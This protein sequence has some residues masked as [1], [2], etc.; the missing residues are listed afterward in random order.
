MITQL[1]DSLKRAAIRIQDLVWTKSRGKHELLQEDV[2]V[3]S[4][5]KAETQEE[6]EEII[7]ISDLEFTPVHERECADIMVMEISKVLEN[8]RP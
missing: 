1:L 4:S 2:A 6:K 3:T 7:H 8:R 5:G